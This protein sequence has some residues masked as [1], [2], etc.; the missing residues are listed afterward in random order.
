VATGEPVY[1]ETTLQGAILALTAASHL[2][3][4]AFEYAAGSNR[5]AGQKA[6]AG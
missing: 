2:R 6:P 1:R 5:G 3:V 4:G